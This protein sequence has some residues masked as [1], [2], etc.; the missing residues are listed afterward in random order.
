LNGLV[1][2]HAR[3]APVDGQTLARMTAALQPRDPDA[4]RVWADGSVALAASPARLG[5]RLFVA[6]DARIDAR[7][8]LLARLAGQGR[9]AAADLSDAELLLHA[10]DVWAEACLQHLLGD[11]SFALWDATRRRLLCAVD[12]LGVKPF[13]FAER[14]GLFAGSNS[15]ACVRFHPQVRDD[16]DEVAVGD[17]LFSGLYQDRGRTIYADVARL[18]PG[19]FLVVDDGGTRLHRYFDWP[20]PAEGP[21]RRAGDVIDGF[22]ELLG[23]AVADRLRT[24]RVAVYMS[25]G[26]DSTLVA[27]TAKR[28]LARRFG[29]F[30]LAA[31][32]RV[33]GGLVPDQERQY[34]A[35]AASGLSISIDVQDCDAGLP[36]DWVG[37]L[38]PPE[39]IARV[40]LG[41]EL[42]QAA[43]LGARFSVALTGYDG[44]ALL[45]AAIHLHW[46]DRLVQ[47]R[48]LGLARDFAWVAARRRAIPPM[49]AR[50][51]V[52]GWL[53]RR[54]G[55]DAAPVRPP[56]MR[57][58]LWLQ[59]GLAE[60]WRPPPRQAAGQ[61]RGQALRMFVQPAWRAVFD[62]YDPALSGVPVDVRHPLLDLRLIRFA[63]ALP[64]V[65]WCVDKELLRRS[66]AGLPDDVRR[67]PKTPLAGDFDAA[68]F[69]RQ[70]RAG[71][72][73]WQA[74]ELS[75]FLDPAAVEDALAADLRGEADLWP[76]LRAIGLGAWMQ[77]SA[78]ARLSR[79]S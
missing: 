45:G 3:G 69:R 62:R 39:P 31:F 55:S 52:A 41:P 43:R 53:A 1:A 59:A 40:A 22:Q 5:D 72:I 61:A 75:R 15:L 28:E 70:W 76:L 44:D 30:E 19:H 50:T 4:N 64:A 20:E 48:W 54:R 38:A 23:R 66:A 14:G 13:Y 47:G 71:M 18:P 26:L 74:C 58:S 2:L 11:F 17:F 73:P 32:T 77:R 63:F 6:A 9:P 65:P 56:W 35:Q 46:R 42:D 24:P 49:G 8:D 12:P 78:C 60:R 25:G 27:L 57:E 7:D 33:S 29:A 68:L 21:P 79:R 67:R 51:M 37:R 34:A 10:Y 36:F 16:L